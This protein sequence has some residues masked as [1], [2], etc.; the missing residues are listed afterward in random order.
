M[1]AGVII[2]ARTL[3]KSGSIGGRA[4]MSMLFQ[5]ISP[6]ADVASASD[7]EIAG[8]P[9]A[10]RM[11]SAPARAVSTAATACPSATPAAMSLA[12]ARPACSAACRCS[13]ALS[14][15]CST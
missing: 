7:C 11:P 1:S 8:D 14:V 13:P 6:R 5:G 4:G 10:V 9:P 2:H 3:P 12:A 15:I